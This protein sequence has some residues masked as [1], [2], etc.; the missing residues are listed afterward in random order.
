M[1]KTILVASLFAMASGSALA[2]DSSITLKWEHKLLDG[3]TDRP[4][5]EFG[6]RMDNGFKFGFEQA[7]QYDRSQKEIDSGFAPEQYELTFKTD[8]RFRWGDKNEYQAG[9]LL[10]YQVKET[11]ETIRFG[12][13]YGYQF[14]RDFSAKVRVRYSQN[15]D[16]MSLGKDYRNDYNKEMRYDLWLTY[17]WNDFTFVWDAIFLQKL[18]QDA[19][20]SDHVYDNNDTFAMENEFSAE[21]RLPNA[22]SHA[23]YGKFKLKQEL[24]KNSVLNGDYAENYGKRDNAIEF[25]Y[26]YRF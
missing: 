22:R 8:Y 1:K 10:D 24:L 12:A 20:G 16:R 9:P 19:S 18:S 15:I 4:K 23:F 7:W 21:Y 5:F 3:R 11:A 13:F 26:K 17:R 2:A 14:S 6:H 25:G